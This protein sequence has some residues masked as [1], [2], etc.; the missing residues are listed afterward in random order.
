MKK[1]SMEERALGFGI[2]TI[3]IAGIS[4]MLYGVYHQ[5]WWAGFGLVI[6]MTSL[7]SW[8]A[9]FIGEC[10][11]PNMEEPASSIRNAS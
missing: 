6:L 11:A 4:L 5:E 9:M 8:V 2:A 7:L 3:G 1:R 10:R